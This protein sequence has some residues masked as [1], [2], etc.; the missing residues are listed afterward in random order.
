MTPWN[1]L[2][3]Q[4]G[5]TAFL[6]YRQWINRRSE[7][8]RRAP[9]AILTYHRVAEDQLTPW[10]VPTVTFVRQIRWLLK[11]FEMISLEE[12][13]RRIRNSENNRVAVSLTFDDGYSENCREAIPLL[14][15]ER[16]PCT[17]FV[18]VRN[19]FD[20]KPF[21]HDEA[22]GY[23]FPPNNLEQLRAM[24]A[25]GVE[26]GSHSYDHVNLG[27]ISD[28]A[29]IARE[30]V[31][32]R[33]DLESAV[34]RRVRYFAFPYGRYADLN[35]AA[36]KT[37]SRAGYEAACSAYGGYNFPGDDP[38]HLQRICVD[39][40]MIRFKNRAAVDPRK[41]NLPRFEWED[42]EWPSPMS[43]GCR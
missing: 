4:L 36:F 26:I 40:N 22:A 6:P 11:H 1:S 15:K 13:Q 20:G 18:T 39:A 5:Y 43:R 32:S 23:Q 21:G 17:Y 31:E 16:I 33:I 3:L 37:A 35:A 28:R 34:G 27:A 24:A 9:I 7:I 12:A 42:V 2:L 30:V 38:F 19:V 29:Q 8:E 41:I 14:V 10:T 25:A